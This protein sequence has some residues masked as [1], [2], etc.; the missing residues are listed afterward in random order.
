MQRSV[1]EIPSKYRHIFEKFANFNRMQSEIID[2]VLQTDKSIVV[3]APTGSGKTVI[4]ELAIVRLLR[5][6]DEAANKDEFKIIYIAPIK[7][8]CNEITADWKLKFDQ[9]GV[10]CGSVTGDDNDFDLNTSKF[11][12]IVT[13]PEKFDSLSRKWNACDYMRAI[14]L[15]MIDE[16]HLLNE[17]KRGP[18]LEAVVS[19]MKTT[20]LKLNQQND[21]TDRIRFIAVSATIPNIDDL[22]S[23]LD[24]KDNTICHK[25]SEDL[26]PVKLERHV[27]GYPYYNSTPFRF[28]MSLTYKLPPIIEKYSNNKPAL[29]FCNSRRS[30]EM[31][32]TT[33]IDKVRLN[34]SDEQRQKILTLSSQIEDVKLRKTVSS[35]VAFHHAGLCVSDKKLIEEYFRSASL[36]IL[37]STNTLAMGVNLPAYLTVIKSTEMLVSGAV[38]ELSEA[39]V[40]QM[41]GRAGRPQFDDHGVAV[42]MTQST[43]V[44]KYESLISGTAPIESHLHNHLIEH[45]NSEIVSQTMS[46]MD[47]VAHW[48][49]SSYL[50]IRA[51][52]KPLHYG[53]PANATV[54]T[55]EQ[56]L[57]ELCVT[58]IE[59]LKKYGLVI[60][61][62]SSL[63][64][65]QLG[66]LMAHFYLNFETMKH[67]TT[68]TGTENVQEIFGTLI[69]CPDFSNGYHLRMNDKKF[70]N[71]LNKSSPEN[72]CIR[73]PIQGKVKTVT[74]KISCLM[75]AVLGNIPVND[76]SI[77]EEA[78]Q[79]IKLG[80]RIGRALQEYI[81]I[82]DTK[83]NFSALTSILLLLKG[84]HANLWENSTYVFK[85]FNKIGHVYSKVLA[86]NGKTTFESILNSTPSDIEMILKKRPPFGKD[87]LDGVIILP[88]FTLNVNV[89]REEKQIYIVV[90]QVNPKFV[91]DS[92]SRGITLIVGDSTNETLFV[93]HRVQYFLGKYGKFERSFSLKNPSAST[94]TAHLI[95]NGIVGLDKSE[96]INLRPDERSLPIQVP[97][98]IQTTAPILVSAPKRKSAEK[99]QTKRQTKQR[100]ISDYLAPPN[101]TPKQAQKRKANTKSNGKKAKS[102]QDECDRQMALMENDGIGVIDLTEVNNPPDAVDTSNDITEYNRAVGNNRITTNTKQSA[103]DFLQKFKMPTKGVFKFVQPP[104]TLQNLSQV[105]REDS[106][107]CVSDATVG[108]SEDLLSPISDLPGNQLPAIHNVRSNS[109]PKAMVN[110]RSR[111]EVNEADCSSDTRNR[112]KSTNLQDEPKTIESNDD[113]K[114]VYVPSCIKAMFG[115]QSQTIPSRVQI[116][117]EKTMPKKKDIN[118]SYNHLLKPIE[119][120]VTSPN[121]QNY[122]LCD[123]IEEQHKLHRTPATRQSP[124]FPFHDFYIHN[125]SAAKELE[126]ID[127]ISHASKDVSV[128]EG[129]FFSLEY[130]ALPSSYEFLTETTQTKDQPMRPLQPT[131]ITGK[132]TPMTLNEH[133][134]SKQSYFHKKLQMPQLSTAGPS[135]HH[136]PLKVAPQVPQSPFLPQYY[137]YSKGVSKVSGGESRSFFTEP[138]DPFMNDDWFESTSRRSQQKPTSSIFSQ[139]DYGSSSHQGGFIPSQSRFHW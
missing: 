78:S 42:I 40:L 100:K 68:I 135:T 138:T 125:F 101:S 66:R 70:L 27:L 17:D 84:L 9:L 39:V 46:N 113:N 64:A 96:T 41:I 89:K 2:K 81:A 50:Y 10:L 130:D 4:L 99:P 8:L 136:P 102:S 117:S 116:Q 111:Q 20:R 33:I 65:T 93:D 98:P 106:S 115:S 85:Q 19:R 49:R 11:S 103:I 73:F 71:A 35:G 110:D 67:F 47:L 36:P 34:L 127:R 14:K 5:K 44:N 132:T 79:L 124:A 80:Q 52:K 28:D 56:R 55:V 107:L 122:S 83:N 120:T 90:E 18:I 86:T 76:S 97:E 54:E 137:S 139:I 16:V 75:Q 92:S 88:Q 133:K 24:D 1:Q 74:D 95:H 38:H 91:C 43:K 77:T 72:D 119:K 57:Q 118:F 6:I 60:E 63:R 69:T 126:R 21:S 109:F 134:Y 26:R 7:A 51:I 112:T 25:V 58:A 108:G 61:T 131:K 29:I 12:I 104:K 37:F 82:L 31:G 123:V 13:T 15:L 48:I 129:F 45:L 30:A 94:V 62:N 3:S 105:Q 87:F 59:E 128:N 23:W 53:F 32:A 121:S 114:N 22:A